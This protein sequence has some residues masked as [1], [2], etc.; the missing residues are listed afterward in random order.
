MA[1]SKTE[2]FG[3]VPVVPQAQLARPRISQRDILPQQ[4]KTHQMGEVVQVLPRLETNSLLSA[5]ASAVPNGNNVVVTVTTEQIGDAVILS[6]VEHGV[7]VG[8]VSD[9]NEIGGYNSTIDESLWQVI[10]PSYST[11]R[12]DGHNSVFQLYV[13][14]ISAGTVDLHF[15]FRVK[16]ITVPSGAN[17]VA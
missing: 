16:Y 13:R 1:R 11:Q 2:R 9:A 4:I 7:F 10:G 12:G 8:S 5:T 14:N 6:V 3:A 17:T 15:R